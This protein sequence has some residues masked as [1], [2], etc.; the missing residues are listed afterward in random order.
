ML[1]CFKHY[2]FLHKA[3]VY[4]VLPSRIFNFQLRFYRVTCLLQVQHVELYYYYRE[5][6]L[7]VISILHKNLLVDK[8]KFP[9]NI[10]W[11]TKI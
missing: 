10:T 8:K 2:A 7:S 1:A 5:G 9:E 6:E 11:N 3:V 4:G